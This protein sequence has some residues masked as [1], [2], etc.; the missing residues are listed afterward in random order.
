MYTLSKASRWTD[1]NWLTNKK[2]TLP[3]LFPQVQLTRENVNFYNWNNGS[4]QK[5]PSKNSGLGL[6]G[7]DFAGLADSACGFYPFYHWKSGQPHMVPTEGILW[8]VGHGSNRIH[9]NL[10]LAKIYQAGDSMCIMVNLRVKNQWISTYFN[11]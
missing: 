6:P 7:L 8:E 1:V 5:K 4:L 9:L 2:S 11:K 3:Y 10:D